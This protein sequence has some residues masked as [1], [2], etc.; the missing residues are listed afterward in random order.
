MKKVLNYV[1][2]DSNALRLNGDSVALSRAHKYNE[3]LIIYDQYGWRDGGRP[4][5]VRIIFPPF[6]SYTVVEKG[7]LYAVGSYTIVSS[8]TVGIFQHVF[9][10]PKVLDELSFYIKIQLLHSNISDAGWSYHYEFD[11]KE[12]QYFNRK[13]GEK[14]VGTLN[15]IRAMNLFDEM[16]RLQSRIKVMGD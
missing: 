5:D 15:V 11:T 3:P 16:I 9:S 13:T 10:N 7:D 8:N 1:T 12:D 2:G 4:R 6:E 14:I